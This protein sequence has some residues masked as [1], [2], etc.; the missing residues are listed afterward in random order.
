LDKSAIQSVTPSQ[1]YAWEGP[2]PNVDLTP[3]TES[4]VRP[5]FSTI[6]ITQVELVLLCASPALQ[7]AYKAGSGPLVLQLGPPNASVPSRVTLNSGGILAGAPY[8]SVTQPAVPAPAST[9]ASPSWTLQTSGTDLQSMYPSQFVQQVSSG[10]TAYYHLIPTA[11]DDI[12]MIC[13][14]SAQ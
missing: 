13:H 4:C 5:A 10:G 8:G 3:Y 9:G 11:V 6:K 1:I 7:A 12:L 2:D 14:Y